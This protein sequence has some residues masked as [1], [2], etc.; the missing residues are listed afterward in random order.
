[1]NTDINLGEHIIVIVNVNVDLGLNVCV[2]VNFRV[3]EHMLPNMN[4]ED[5]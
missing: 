4:F 2:N 1:M 5:E 3:N